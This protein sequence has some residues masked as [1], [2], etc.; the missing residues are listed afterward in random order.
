MQ[1]GFK[2][3]ATE[4]A[5]AAVACT[6]FMLISA[7]IFAVIVKAYAPA[8]SVVT[9][10]NWILKGVGAF[11]S[12]LIFIHIGRA[13]FKGAAA[14]VLSCLLTMLLF[15]AIGGFHVTA[16]FPLELLFSAAL[17]ALGGMLGVKIRKETR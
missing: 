10:V 9:A 1:T 17:G 11:L 5:F 2:K 3:A 12:S 8:Q 13:V 4:V 14:G 16:F 15:G 7:A 6:V